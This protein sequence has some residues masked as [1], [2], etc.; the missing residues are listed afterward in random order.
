MKVRTRKS[1]QRASV[2]NHASGILRKKGREDK[3]TVDQWETVANLLITS[4]S[5]SGRMFSI[6]VF[7]LIGWQ[8]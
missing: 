8:F 6:V 1:S 3:K 4:S 7:L 2:N 5:K